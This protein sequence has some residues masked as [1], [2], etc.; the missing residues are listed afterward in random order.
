MYTKN[1]P[2]AYVKESKLGVNQIRW[3]SEFALFDFNIKYRS[4]KSNQAADTLSHHPMTENE[5]LSDSESDGYKTIS[6]AVMCN[7][8][9]EIIKGKK[10]PLELKRAV[11]TE[12]I[13]QVPDSGKIKVHSEMVDVLSQVTPGM[14]KEAQEEDVDISKTICYVK[15]GR[16]L[17]LA[18]IR[19]IK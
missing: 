3:L 18:Q 1:N 10:L 6:Y 2:L 16:K 8:L 12:I 7:D 9:S 4:G 19:N 17:M 15:S 14:M 13:Q 11:Q 5:I